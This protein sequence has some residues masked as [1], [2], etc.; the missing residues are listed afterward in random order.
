[1]AL[2]GIPLRE[3]NRQRRAVNDFPYAWIFK[4][5]S[6]ELITEQ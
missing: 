6:L 2:E 5:E 1:V 4:K 3:M